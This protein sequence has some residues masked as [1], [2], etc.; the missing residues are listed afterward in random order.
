MR[1]SEKQRQGKP[2]PAQP[3]FQQQRQVSHLNPITS[4]QSLFMD[5][6]KSKQLVI[7]DGSSGTG[8][9]YIA[10]WWAAK[11][12]IERNIKKIILIRCYQPLAGRT[13]GF[14]PG[15]AT[16]KLMPFYRQMVDYLEEFLGKDRI[17]IAMKHGDIEICSLENIRGRSWDNAIVIVDESQ[18]LFIP[19]VQALVTRLGEYSQMILVGDASGFQSD[20]HGSMDGLTYLQKLVLKYH[21]DSCSTITFTSE[22]IVRSGLVKEFVKAFESEVTEEKIGYQVVTQKEIYS[23]IKKGR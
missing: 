5:A 13:I 1:R 17:E 9:T 8:K 14:I 20:F 10:C 4:N 23:Q 6:L 11:N 3:K 19:E 7:A 15:D 22:D 21:I 12:L 16:E 2:I 18:G